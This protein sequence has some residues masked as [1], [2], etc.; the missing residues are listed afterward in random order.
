MSLAIS[1][2][3]Y[4]WVV[5]KGGQSNRR[6][7]SYTYVLTTYLYISREKEKRCG[8]RSLGRWCVL[9]GGALYTP[10]HS[11]SPEIMEW[12]DTR[13]MQPSTNRLGPVWIGEKENGTRERR[14]NENRH[15]T[16]LAAGRRLGDHKIILVS[17]C[18]SP[19]DLPV[20]YIGRY[21]SSIVPQPTKYSATGLSRQ[22]IR[23]DNESERHFMRC[24]QAN[25]Q[26]N[27]Q[28]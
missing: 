18:G 10:A 12:A 11:S 4:S 20:S 5:R 27:E 16:T 24:Y 9:R 23:H 28:T 14:D 15:S 2:S 6:R 3:E 22:Q 13:T 25:E 19:T 8:V 26:T 21:F 7:A 1:R 17:S